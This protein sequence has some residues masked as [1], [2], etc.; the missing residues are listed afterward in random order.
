[1][2]MLIQ[3]WKEAERGHDEF[4]WSYCSTRKHDVKN[5]ML[6]QIMPKEVLKKMNSVVHEARAKLDIPQYCCVEGRNKIVRNNQ[7]IVVSKL[8]NKRHDFVN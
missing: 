8:R 4:G 7:L 3:N 2:L 1:M 6:T 5:L